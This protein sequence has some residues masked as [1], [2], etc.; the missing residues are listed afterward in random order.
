LKLFFPLIVLFL[1]FTVE[2]KVALKIF[3]SFYVKVT[4]R[5]EGKLQCT[6][7][8]VGLMNNPSFSGWLV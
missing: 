8:F 5:E 1:F 6:E 3:F 7:E 4:R 2:K